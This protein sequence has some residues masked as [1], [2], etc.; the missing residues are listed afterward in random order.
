MWIH[1]GL[2]VCVV[3]QSFVKEKVT[4]VQADGKTYYVE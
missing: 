4:A 1:L 2:G 3:D